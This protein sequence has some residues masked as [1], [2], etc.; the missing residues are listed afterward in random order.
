MLNGY[1]TLFI[2]ADVI[3]SQYHPCKSASKDLQAV[4]IKFYSCNFKKM[5]NVI[6]DF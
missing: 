3:L 6:Y 2:T 1:V 5:Y 4:F